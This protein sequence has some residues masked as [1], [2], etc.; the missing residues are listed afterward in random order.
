MYRRS[1]IV[2]PATVCSDVLPKCRP[3]RLAFLPRLFN[4]VAGL[5]KVYNRRNRV[6]EHNHRFCVQARGNG[7]LFY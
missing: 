1:W 5:R 7:E 4:R 6:T 3:R 2:I